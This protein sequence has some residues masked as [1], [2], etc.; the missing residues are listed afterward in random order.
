MTASPLQAKHVTTCRFLDNVL[1]IGGED[2]STRSEMP[3]AQ[4][5]LLLKH[6]GANAA[7]CGDL[8]YI[9]MIAGECVTVFALNLDHSAQLQPLVGQFEVGAAA[10]FALR[11]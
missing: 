3:V 9:I 7:L 10:C 8:G 5:E 4:S 2:K 11:I 6:K 1:V